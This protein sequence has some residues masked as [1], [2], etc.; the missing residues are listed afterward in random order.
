MRRARIRDSRLL[1]PAELERIVDRHVG[2]RAARTNRPRIPD[3]I[4]IGRHGLVV[5]QGRHR[6][7]LLPQV[8]TGVGLDRRDQFLAQTLRQSGPRRA[9]PGSAARRCF[10]S[11]RTCLGSVINESDCDRDCRRLPTTPTETCSLARTCPS[12]AGCRAPSTGRRRP[13]ARRCRSSRSPRGSGGRACCRLRRS[14]CF[15]AGS[16]RPAIHPVVAHNSYLINLAAADPAL[17]AQSIDALGDELDRAEALG[18]SGARHAPRVATRRAREA[19]GL[20]LIAA[21]HRRVS[22]RARPPREDDDPPRTH[23]R[24]GHQPGTPLRASARRSSSCLDG[25]PRVGVCLDTCHLLAAGYDICSEPGLRVDVRG[26]SIASW[27]W[28]GCGRFT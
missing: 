4:V 28:T 17:R 25:S 18:P 2:P 21:G 14:R 13:A 24:S 6:G 11:R 8:A 1:S 12:P 16:T 3:A 19:E 15:A 23:R 9:T 5:E 26:A 20:E 7:L 10:A 27:A 22:L